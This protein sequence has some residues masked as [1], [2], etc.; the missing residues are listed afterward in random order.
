MSYTNKQEIIYRKKSLNVWS[1]Y[2]KVNFSVKDVD[3]DGD[4]DVVITGTDVSNVKKDIASDSEALLKRDFGD[5]LY[6]DGKGF[7]SLKSQNTTN[8]I[9]S[10]IR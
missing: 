1:Q 3:K 8:S 7:F 4:G 10:L 9:D 2:F 5:T 6:N